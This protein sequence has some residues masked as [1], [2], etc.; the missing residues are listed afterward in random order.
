MG[1]NELGDPMAS[2]SLQFPIINGDPMAMGGTWTTMAKA[3]LTMQILARAKVMVANP[4]AKA[5][6]MVARQIMARAKVSQRE[7]P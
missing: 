4:M 5:K 3:G 7:N 1:T 6:G 2:G